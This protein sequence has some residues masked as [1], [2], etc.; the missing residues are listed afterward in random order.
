MLTAVE[1]LFTTPYLSL[2]DDFLAKVRETRQGYVPLSLA[3]SEASY[4]HVELDE[5]IRILNQS[6][7]VVL[8]LPSTSSSSLSSTVS[9]SSS[10]SSSPSSSSPVPQQPINDGTTSTGPNYNTIPIIRQKLPLE[11]VTI[12]DTQRHTLIIDNLSNEINLSSIENF[13]LRNDENVLGSSTIITLDPM[14]I[15]SCSRLIE[16]GTATDTINKIV[17][18]IL[19]DSLAVSKLRF[20]LLYCRD[21]TIANDYYTRYQNLTD[22]STLPFRINYFIPNQ[23]RKGSISGSQQASPSPP[24]LSNDNGT[25]GN[26]FSHSPPPLTATSTTTTTTT[27][28][29]STNSTTP[30]NGIVGITN[31]LELQQGLITPRSRRNSSNSNNNDHP[32]SSTTASLPE[33]SIHTLSSATTPTNN[34]LHSA[35]ITTDNV[36]VTTTATTTP[37][38][39][40]FEAFSGRRSRSSSKDEDVK[41]W[42]NIRGGETNTHTVSE[43]SIQSVTIDNPTIST[44]NPTT[45]GI[46]SPDAHSKPPRSSLGNSS[47]GKPPLSTAG[48]L[49]TTPGSNGKPPVNPSSSSRRNSAGTTPIDKPLD[50]LGEMGFGHVYVPRSRRTSATGTVEPTGT[51]SSGTSTNP[52][53]TATNNLITTLQ[54]IAVPV[55]N[56]AAGP[57]KGPERNFARRKSSITDINQALLNANLEGSTSISS[58][59]SAKNN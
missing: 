11:R 45:G 2:H 10:A 3:L 28:G 7:A 39:K 6:T 13:L 41:K 42:E 22:K 57:E 46:M 54:E 9:S 37:A 50:T 25:N 36:N 17:Q 20:A 1:K 16:P 5:A 58:T 43:Q 55:A 23:R 33:H 27:I 19:G 56:F 15:I 14:N 53:A 12:P 49:S 44:V 38:S 34:S 21:E 18:P 52:T 51:P 31:T 59:N 26:I 35:S 4:G 47:G 32:L 30:S 40:G 8:Q 48:T 24:T 29:R